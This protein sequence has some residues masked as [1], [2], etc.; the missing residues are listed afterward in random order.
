MCAGDGV[1]V[2]DGVRGGVVGWVI[3]SA[4]DLVVGDAGSIT[5]AMD[6]L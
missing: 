1:D 2:A 3:D 4:D 6:F 5:Q